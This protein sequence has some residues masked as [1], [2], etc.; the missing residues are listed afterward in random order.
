MSAPYTPAPSWPTPERRIT[1]DIYESDNATHVATLETDSAREWTDELNAAGSAS[2]QVPLYVP[3]G[4]GTGVEANPEADLLTR[5]RIAGFSL[6]GTPRFA[7]VI[8]PRRQTSISRDGHRSLARSVAAQGLL[9]EWAR[10]VVPPAPG[11]FA[12]DVT[13]RRWGW[14]CDQNNLSFA[15]SP[16]T[17]TRPVFGPGVE[18]PEPWIDAFGGVLDGYRYWWFDFTT[19]S[20]ISLSL[21]VAFIQARVWVNSVPAGEGDPPPKS[22]WENTWH[23]GMSLDAGTHRFALDIGDLGGSDARFALTAYEIEDPETGRMNG[24]TILFRSGYSTGVTMYPWKASNTPGGVTAKQ[25][26]RRFLTE[27]DAQQGVLGD[28]TLYG[29][30]DTIDANG[31]PLPLIADFP[32]AVGATGE[33]LLRALT[34]AHC[35]IAV[36]APGAGKVVFVYRWRE[37]GTY[38]T[39]PGVV[40]VFFDDIFAPLVPSNGKAANLVELDHEERL[41]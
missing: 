26:L 37:R 18:H 21:H 11:A 40:P 17:I 25:I 3:T 22:N 29:A 12:F 41:P 4:T 8:R 6:D 32:I 2:L 23:V 36:S 35:D 10:A 13:T 7:A 19:A 15:A 1:V 34:A 28:W 5:G 30:D 27:A 9:S 20:A 33:D 16:S 14:M 31:N 24:D 39:N 38:H